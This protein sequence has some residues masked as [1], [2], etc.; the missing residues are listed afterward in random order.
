MY[1]HWHHY[2]LDRVDSMAYGILIPEGD[3]TTTIESEVTCPACIALL[4]N[5]KRKYGGHMQETEDKDA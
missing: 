3:T 1:V 2:I 4:R 5:K